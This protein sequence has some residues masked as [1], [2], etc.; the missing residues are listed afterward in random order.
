MQQLTFNTLS[1]R[2]DDSSFTGKI[3]DYAAKQ[4][5]KPREDLV[6][7]VKGMVPVLAM[8]LQDAELAQ[9]AAGA[10]SAYLDAPKN[11]EVK[12]APPAPVSFAIL[13]ATGSMNPMALVKQLNLSVTA[14]Q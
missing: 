14:N 5:N 10:V 12:A 3:F 1:I 7:Q 9:K 4:Q 2:F 13:A 8:Q 11:I 6:N